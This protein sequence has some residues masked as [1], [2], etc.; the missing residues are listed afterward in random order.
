MPS[1][2]MDKEE[3][4]GDNGK[5]RATISGKGKKKAVFGVEGVPLHNIREVRSMMTSNLSHQSHQV[6]VCERAV[7]YYRKASSCKYVL[8]HVSYEGNGIVSERHPWWSNVLD[9]IPRLS[10]TEKVYVT[11]IGSNGKR[12]SWLVRPDQKSCSW[13]ESLV[14]KFS[15]P[16]SL[17]LICY[18]VLCDCEDM[19][20]TS[21][22]PSFSGL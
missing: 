17:K 1:R 19:F 8:S 2:A 6:S 21:A 11:V 18:L 20:E 3:I 13:M 14:N 7:H 16:G 15:K 5:G 12:K 9:G 10:R 22:V 4:D